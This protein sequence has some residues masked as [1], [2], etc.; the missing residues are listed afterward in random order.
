M[1]SGFE[2]FDHTADMGIRV[3]APTMTGLIEP[4]TQ[5]MYS[6]IGELALLES[7]GVD[8][9]EFQPCEDSEPAFLLRDYLDRLLYEFECRHR[10]A[11]SASVQEFST[12]RLSVDVAWRL[13]DPQHSIYYREVKAITYHDLAIRE[14][15]G[16]Y[17]A[18]VIVDI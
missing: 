15:P 3:F 1:Q 4:A 16:G 2:T 8:R 13:V 12:L 14:I 11:E 10:V 6:L 9:L 5:G 18:T 7:T 17:E